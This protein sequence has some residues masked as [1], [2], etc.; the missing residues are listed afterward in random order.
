MEYMFRDATSFN[1]DVSNWNVEAVTDMRTCSSRDELQRRHL[2]L[3]RRGGD[4]HEYMFHG[5]TSFN[6]DI[7]AWNVQAVTDMS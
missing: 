7:T 6:G 4:E 2:E 3:E 5:A 1:G